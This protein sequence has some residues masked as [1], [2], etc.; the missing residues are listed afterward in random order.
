MFCFEDEGLDGPSGDAWYVF[1]LRGDSQ[2]AGGIIVSYTIAHHDWEMSQAKKGQDNAA[3]TRR[4]QR[5]PDISSVTC[6]VDV[7]T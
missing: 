5:A 7:R 4:W 6:V 2:Y 1:E 3:T